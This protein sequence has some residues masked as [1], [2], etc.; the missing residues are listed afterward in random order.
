VERTAGR[1]RRQGSRGVLNDA[2]AIYFLDS[3]RNR[4][5]SR[6]SFRSPARS[7][8]SVKPQGLRAELIEKSTIMWDRLAFDL[9]AG[10]PGHRAAILRS[11]IL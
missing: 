10:T 4:L 11:E 1:R 8:S 3:M 7:A 5:R 9:A 6:V 2:I